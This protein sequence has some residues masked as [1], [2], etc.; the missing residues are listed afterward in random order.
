MGSN[1]VELAGRLAEFVDR[2]T[3]VVDGLTGT[4]PLREWIDILRAGVDLLTRADGDD[5]WQTGQ[6]QREFA[7]IL[8]GPDRM[9]ASRCSSTMFVLCCIASWRAGR[10]GRISVPAP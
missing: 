9:W 7:D 6:L 3:W 5:S 1:K 10:P 8:T 2:L 4:R